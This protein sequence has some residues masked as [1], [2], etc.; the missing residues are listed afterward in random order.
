MK[1]IDIHALLDFVRLTNEYALIERTINLHGRDTL[2]NDLEHAGQLALVAWF[3]ATQHAPHLS[4]EKILKYSLAHDLVEVYAGDVYI[5]DTDTQKHEQKDARERAALATLQE[6]FPHFPELHE[7]IRGYMEKIE[8]E[9][10]FVSKV[11]KLLPIL[12][13][14][15]SQGRGWKERNITLEMIVTN[16]KEKI[17]DHFPTREYFDILAAI[18][19][20]KEKDFF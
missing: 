8:E 1:N 13:S 6:R 5:Y 12:N 10:V 14:Y 15:R 16:K 2:E 17:G 11:D 3:L 9:A 4:H 19:K 18:L 20:E 7:Y